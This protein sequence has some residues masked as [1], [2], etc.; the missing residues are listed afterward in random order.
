M[1][2]VMHRSRERLIIFTRYPEPGRTKTRLI[3]ALGALGAAEL[4][5]RMTEQ[6]IA[7]AR[8][9]AARQAVALEICYTGGDAALM[10]RWL[11]ADLPLRAQSGGDLGA[12]MREAFQ[13]AFQQGG[14]RVV[15]M[16]SDCP[17]ITSDIL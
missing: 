8:R 15:I 6:A 4:H 13:R 5:R 1:L 16:G 10:Q 7:T 11:G 17:G 3:P 2:Q 9:L 12:R 14:A